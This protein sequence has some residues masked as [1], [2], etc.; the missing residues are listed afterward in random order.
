[1]VRRREQGEEEESKGER[2]R[3]RESRAP[4]QI[5][6]LACTVHNHH[7]MSSIARRMRKAKV[8]CEQE[9]NKTLV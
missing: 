1:M 8:N 3:E 7:S 2:E 9:R 4:S 5:F 6:S